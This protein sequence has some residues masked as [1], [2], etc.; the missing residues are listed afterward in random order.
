VGGVDWSAMPTRISMGWSIRAKS[1]SEKTATP[2]RAQCSHQ[3][4][5]AQG[6]QDVKGSSLASPPDDY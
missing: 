3:H 2:A 5:Y 4:Q 1:S 6:A